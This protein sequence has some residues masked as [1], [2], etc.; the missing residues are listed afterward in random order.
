MAMWRFE[1]IERAKTQPSLD[2]ECG[3]VTDLNKAGFQAVES[4]VRSSEADRTA[5]ELS[6]HSFSGQKC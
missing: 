3:L 5:L 4:I 1:R 6:S 2:C